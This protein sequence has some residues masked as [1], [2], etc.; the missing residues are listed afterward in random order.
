MGISDA[1]LSLTER[2]RRHLKDSWTEIFSKKIFPFLDEDRFRVL[3]SDNPVNVYFGLL[4]LRKIFSRSD[5]EALNSL[6]FDIRYQYALHTT[7][8]QEQ[9]ISKNSLTN[10]RAAA[11]KYIQEYGVDWTEPLR[12]DIYGLSHNAFLRVILYQ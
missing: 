12:L 1:L 5:E 7:S 10:F 8:F 2:E 3:Y 4:I 6:M 9:P 11:Y